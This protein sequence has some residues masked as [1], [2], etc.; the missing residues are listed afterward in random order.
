MYMPSKQAVEGSNPSAFTAKPTDFSGFFAF[1]V[2][3]IYLIPTFT[4]TF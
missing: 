1:S 4:D 3:R 2:F